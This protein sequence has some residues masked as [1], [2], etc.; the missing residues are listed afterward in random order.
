MLEYAYVRQKPLLS[1]PTY[2]T[3]KRGEI[4]VGYEETFDGW[5]C[6]AT[7]PGWIIK[8]MQGQQGVGEI[9]SP[10]GNPPVL[11][12]PRPLRKSGPIKFE[13]VFK[14]HVAVRSEPSKD[15]RIEGLKRKGE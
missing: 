5:V 7:E 1:A 4:I 10:V 13:V 14:P 9:L 2:G 8:D 15:A 12:V 11:A 6:L 3:K